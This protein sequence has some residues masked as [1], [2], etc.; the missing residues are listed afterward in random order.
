MTD[1]PTFRFFSRSGALS[2]RNIGYEV[3]RETGENISI[4]RA[5]QTD[6]LPDDHVSC[7]KRKPLQATAPLIEDQRDE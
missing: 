4:L 5:R 1:A 2:T 7:Q 6:H 3:R